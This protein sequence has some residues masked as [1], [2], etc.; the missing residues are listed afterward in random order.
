MP[1]QTALL[2]LVQEC[3]H[4]VKQRACGALR[5]GTLLQLEVRRAVTFGS[6]GD[7]VD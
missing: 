7:K 5:C 1:R 2:H 3:M 4:V 6:L